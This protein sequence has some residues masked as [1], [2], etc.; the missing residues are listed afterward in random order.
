MTRT[1]HH[2]RPAPSGWRSLPDSILLALARPGL[3]RAESLCP[4][5]ATIEH[6]ACGDLRAQAIVAEWRPHFTITTEAAHG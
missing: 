3:A 5:A 1:H 2:H 6:A 4:S